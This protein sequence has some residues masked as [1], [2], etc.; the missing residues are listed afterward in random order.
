MKPVRS[1]WWWVAGAVFASSLLSWFIDRH[2][3]LTIQAMVYLAGV[4]AVAYRC[5]RTQ[6]AVTA[7]LSV[8]ALNLL[9]VPPRGSLSVDGIEH[10]V[11]LATLL[12]VAFL[13][14][15]LA[16]N[17]RRETALARLGEQRAQRHCKTWPASCRCSTTKRRSCPWPRAAC[18]RP[19][20]PRH[21]WC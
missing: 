9:F 13:V 20:A 19:T 16:A 3:S 12:V 14:S 8:L 11:T 5:T 2:V 1:G 10:L 15:T 17:L 7:V 21:W 18:A 4:V 6:S